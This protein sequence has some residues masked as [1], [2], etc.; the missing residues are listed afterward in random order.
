MVVVM[1][2]M[3]RDDIARICNFN[4]PSREY[5]CGGIASESAY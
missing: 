4:V 2:V 5:D 3:A 1:V